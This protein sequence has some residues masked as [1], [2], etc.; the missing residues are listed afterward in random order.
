MTAGRFVIAYDASK[1]PVAEEVLTAFI[2][3]NKHVLQ[4]S[5][6]FPGAYLVKSESDARDITN[7]LDDLMVRCN[8]IVVKIFKTGGN[9]WNGRLPKDVWSWFA[10]SVDD[11]SQVLGLE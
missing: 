9:N 5:K 8:F 3:N 1:L 2:K 7:S 10:E 11:E 6:I 4:W